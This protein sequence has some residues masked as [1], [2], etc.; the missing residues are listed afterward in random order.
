MTG[1][2]ELH[3]DHMSSRFDRTPLSLF[4]AIRDS[5]KAG[6]EILTFTEV[7]NDR[8]AAQLRAFGWKVLRDDRGDLG[9]VAIAFNPQVWA[10]E[11]H[12]TYVL[13][14]DSGPGGREVAIV[15]LLRHVATKR[16]LL[17]STSH[18]PSAV[19]GRWGALTRRVRVYQSSLQNWRRIIRHWYRTEVPDGI[20]ITAD[21]NLN[22]HRAWVRAYFRAA[23]PG[24]RIPV[25]WPKQGTHAGGRL[26]DFPLGRRIRTLVF[27]VLPADPSSDHRRIRIRG[28][29]APRP[30]RR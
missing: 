23:W 27:A 10:V 5:I 7:A 25:A 24:V 3:V 26:I 4:N 17:I 30:R 11:K 1:V 12:R 19:E 21:W 14:P 29:I 2:A 9:E 15:A 20:L 28:T 6:A 8:R 13:G 16:T 18:M 22:L